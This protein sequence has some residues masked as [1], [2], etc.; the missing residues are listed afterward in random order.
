MHLSHGRL[1]HQL[2]GLAKRYLT[3]NRNIRA[4]KTNKGFTATRQIVSMILVSLSNRLR[5]QFRAQHELQILLQNF[6]YIKPS[7]S[8]L[9]TTG[10]IY[11]G[12]PTLILYLP[13]PTNAASK[14]LYS[15]NMQLSL[16]STFAALAV[17]VS[18]TTPGSL[19]LKVYLYFQ[20]RS[21]NNFKAAVHN[22]NSVY[23]L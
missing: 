5:D 19:Y 6:L 11:A 22:I 2:S 12:N 13:N 16:S 17:V 1:I 23:V 4:R 10:D 9:K 3:A 18:P 15:I 21:L 8:G 14:P 20:I 7:K